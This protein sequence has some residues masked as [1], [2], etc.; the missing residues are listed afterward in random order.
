MQV[1]ILKLIYATETKDTWK[2]QCWWDIWFIE[3]L[4]L[5]PIHTNACWF[6]NTHFSDAFL[7]IAHTENAEENGDFWQRIVLKTLRF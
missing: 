1:V 4:E 5:G 3:Y 6:E 7:P 2:F